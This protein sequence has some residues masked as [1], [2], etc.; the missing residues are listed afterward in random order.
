VTVDFAGVSPFCDCAYFDVSAAC[1]RRLQ[2][3]LKTE[4]AL[5]KAQ[6]FPVRKFALRA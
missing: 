1:F 3:N 6:N 2:A 5:K 4:K